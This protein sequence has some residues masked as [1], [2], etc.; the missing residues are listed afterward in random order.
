MKAM[1][2]NTT[3]QAERRT[4]E[5]NETQQTQVAGGADLSLAMASATGG[6]RVGGGIRGT[7][8]LFYSTKY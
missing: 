2:P 1:K 7:D 4:R 5:I 3:V 6:V 8:Q